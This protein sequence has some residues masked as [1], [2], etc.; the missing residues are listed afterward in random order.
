[1]AIILVSTNYGCLV[2]VVN[3]HCNNAASTRA[4]SRK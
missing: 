3:M 2:F 4:Q 1:M